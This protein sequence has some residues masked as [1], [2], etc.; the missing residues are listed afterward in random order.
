MEDQIHVELQWLIGRLEQ[1]G[2]TALNQREL[3][4]SAVTNVIAYVCFGH[5]FEHGH[6]QFEQ[7][8]KNLNIF[9]NN[10]LI[11]YRW[12]N[13]FPPLRLFPYS[14]GLKDSIKI[15]RDIFDFIRDEVKQHRKDFDANN[16]RDMID[17]YLKHEESGRHKDNDDAL[18]EDEI[19][20]LI[21]DVFVAGDF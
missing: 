3:L 11:N 10:I 9:F 12:V 19:L 2:A 8:K 18:S 21:L 14:Q 16:L 20:R 13:F 4:F 5:R 1:H 15:I 7:V 6:A 17:T